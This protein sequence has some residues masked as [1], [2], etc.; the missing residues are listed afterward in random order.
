[1]RVASVF[2]LLALLASVTSCTKRETPAVESLIVAD[3]AVESDQIGAVTD[4]LLR[5][6]HRGQPATWP[7]YG[8]DWAQ[9]RYSSLDQIQREN[10][11]QLRPA[12]IAQTGVLG[13][14]EATPIV[15]G[16]EMYVTTP[17]E[18]G[19][20]KVL[21]LDST[22]GETVWQVDLESE[23]RSR[24]AATEDGHL[25]RDF[26]P[27]RGVAVYGDR[28]YVG[29]LN[30]SLLALRRD[31]GD[32][33]FEVQTDSPRI[34]G[35]PL[36][37]QGRI[38]V[39]LSWV[40]RGAV[41]AFDAKSGDLLWTW[42][43]IPS[44][45]DGGWWGD[46]IERLPGREEIDLGRDIAQE[47]ANQVRLSETWRTGG[48]SAPMTP[49]FDHSLGLVYI[50][51]GG[52]DPH[53]F[54]PPAEPHPGDMRWTNSICA[55][56]IETGSMAWCYQFLPHDTKGASGPTPGILINLNIEG[57]MRE[58]V[59]RF[60]GL[61]N[62]YVWDRKGGELL[63]VSDNYIPVENTT[64]GKAGANLIGVAGTVWSPGA[65]SF[66]T[67]LLYST[68][69]RMPEYF[70]PRETQRPGGEYGNIAA[71]NPITGE[72]V[73]TRQTEKPMAGGTLATAGGLV[74]AGRTTGWFDAYDATTGER[75]WSFRTG[76]GCNSAPVTYEVAGR[77][78]VAVSC[79]GHGLLD[80]ESGDA[81]VAFS[82]VPD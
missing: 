55:L 66:E 56:H 64:G 68:N 30:G 47:K 80:P 25:P 76:A 35:A 22:T 79:G 78:Y 31:T 16:L 53:G 32:R 58:A 49:T 21:R 13:T 67:G 10:V 74:F 3:S 17:A 5:I 72:V 9:T 38:I 75:L 37:A 24:L 45:Q 23:E 46:W 14:F 29:T 6:G 81:I 48:G 71:V 28:V 51:I 70:E 62:L 15:L 59:A 44:P 54:P 1:V 73:W 77:Q 4:A 33:I 61:G 52:P 18:Q 50:S 65:Y 63:G 41:Q 39:G 40:D 60:S 36:A 19:L 2:V 7:T 82:L 8:G 12:W 42:H 69:R 11:S 20:Q 43:T 26:G 27:H 34:T 57:R